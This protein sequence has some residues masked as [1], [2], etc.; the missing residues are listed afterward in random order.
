[1]TT[2][3][4]FSAIA[5]IDGHYLNTALY[6]FSRNRFNLQNPEKASDKAHGPRVKINYRILKG[7]LLPEIW[8]KD[9]D[10]PMRD[11]IDLNYYIGY[12]LLPQNHKKMKLGTVK[13]WERSFGFL[14]DA[15]GET[16]FFAHQSDILKKGYR[17]L[18]ENQAVRFV[19]EKKPD[20]KWVAKQILPQNEYARFMDMTQKR[21]F[22]HEMLQEEGY[23]VVA[24]R[25]KP[26]DPLTKNKSVD[27]RIV[28]DIN[29]CVGE[30]D[31]LAVIL[32]G[33]PNYGFLLSDL[34]E[35]NVKTRLVGFKDTM[36]PELLSVAA[37]CN[38]DVVLL[39]NAMEKIEH[40]DGYDSGD[41]YPDGD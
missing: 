39:D 36:H 4:D 28:A 40:K 34:H 23:M 6:V 27:M 29:A 9:L 20:G 33:D 3:G 35:H 16:Q 13:R 26:E 12:P 32:T 17:S 19:P 21:D 8:G 2:N 18:E 38:T 10:A 31:D 22:F 41:Y 30:D 11:N 25:P 37:A 1:M 14:T 7:I 24:C 5:A 15:D